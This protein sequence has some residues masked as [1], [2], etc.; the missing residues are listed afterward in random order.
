MFQFHRLH[1]RRYQGSDVDKTDYIALMKSGWTR[2][3]RAT[4]VKS[5]EYKSTRDERILDRVFKQWKALCK[6]ETANA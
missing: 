3:Y 2:V 6:E 1:G 4:G 5:D